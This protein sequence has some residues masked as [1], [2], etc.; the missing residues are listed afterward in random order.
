[1]KTLSNKETEE[2]FDKILSGEGFL[3]RFS[4]EEADKRGIAKMS[5]NP[6]EK[7]KL[8]SEILKNGGIEKDNSMSDEEFED[9]YFNTYKKRMGE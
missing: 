5:K 6:R 2:I 3:T 4:A 9:W 1:M 7:E 8:Y